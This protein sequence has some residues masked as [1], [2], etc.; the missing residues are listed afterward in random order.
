MT[1]H[2][3]IMRSPTFFFY[4]YEIISVKVIDGP[5]ILFSVKESENKE[6]IAK[7][8]YSF[9]DNSGYTLYNNGADTK[10]SVTNKDGNSEIFEFIYQP[11]NILTESQEHYNDLLIN[12]YLP[13][14]NELEPALL[15]GTTK[16]DLIKRLLLD[17]KDIMRSKGTKQ[18]IEKFFYFIGFL[19]EQIHVL[20]EYR[21]NGNN[22]NS[23][24]D[25][26]LSK[27]ELTSWIADKNITTNPDKSKDI[28]TGN[29]HV[30]FDNWND[31]ITNGI[32]DVN[33]KNMPYRPFSQQNFDEFF[34]SLK[35][36]IA[37]ANKYF[38]LVEQEITFF[39]ISMSVNI[40]MYKS[41]TSLMN[42]I[43]EYDLNAF[44]RNLHID[45]YYN[46]VTNGYIKTPNYL[47]KNCL[48]KDNKAYR[49]E[50]KFTEHQS[51][52]KNNE[53]LYIVDKEYADSEIY[54]GNINVFRR[55]FANILHLNIE[56]PNTY[57]Q[58]TID[59]L[60]NELVKLVVPKQY[61][62]KVLHVEFLT[63]VIG[64][65]KVTVEI[66]DKY[67]SYEKYWYY[68]NIEDDVRL[69]DIDLF[70]SSEILEENFSKNNINLDIDSGSVIY[71]ETK[72]YILPID[73]IPDDLKLYWASDIDITDVKWLSETNV[74]KTNNL[75]L[76][77]EIN[78][79]YKVN[80]VTETIPVLYS[81]Q[82]FE[83]I[84]IPLDELL[85]LV[86]KNNCEILDKDSKNILVRSGNFV[87]D[88]LALRLYDAEERKYVT[89]YLRD[90]F[91]FELDPVF[92]KLFIRK[93]TI[94]SQED[95]QVNSRD[96]L[97]ISSIES[98]INICKET[99]D[100]R[101]ITKEYDETNII[102]D[103]V[104]NFK[105]LDYDIIKREEQVH[106][107]ETQSIYDIEGLIRK[108]IPV[109]FDFPLFPIDKNDENFVYSS[110]TE[111]YP[112]VKSIF[113]RLQK[114]GIQ[115]LFLGDIIVARLNQDRI[116]GETN[117]K[118]ILKDSFNN[119][120]LY[121]TNDYALKYRLKENT[122][123]TIQCMFTI[124][125]KQYSI[126]KTGVVSSWKL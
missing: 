45:L 14:L 38:T 124:N 101:Y 39:G 19:N 98:G 41:I 48:Q 57:V 26:S 99:F 7:S 107:I 29:Y 54:D 85:K 43:F 80:K 68:Y 2:Q 92:D 51:I 25:D 44:R 13:T 64:N 17:F 105:T 123:Y 91:N 96:Y 125:G 42:Q 50:V 77:S 8:D 4:S 46:Y 82:W 12:H 22:F 59:N 60:N 104:F 6:L 5:G 84:V 102:E 35:Y 20:D 122:I 62:E 16:S 63:A 56:S 49:S 90:A 75:T 116:V 27:K 83:F 86:D 113:P 106:I 34:E 32:Q 103:K 52:I 53:E 9:S 37:L 47:V 119:S 61:V 11:D 33:S 36:G 79:N 121:E 108:R 65:F 97:F 66:W 28:K 3:I 31:G 23:N 88:N 55:I 71:Q 120:V 74:S 10:I 118:W 115:L 126:E 93:M 73:K 89:L 110:I 112:I 70:T 76:L 21:K 87:V 78:K 69:L 94:N 58:I 81:D 15:P 30:L 67:N 111:T 100:L 72:N 1:S 18:S 40:P 114:D 24:F 117:I 109:N 95:S